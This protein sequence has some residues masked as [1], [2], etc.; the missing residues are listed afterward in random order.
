MLSLTHEESEDLEIKLS[1]LEK[2][3]NEMDDT[4]VKKVDFLGSRE[5]LKREMEKKMN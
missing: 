3:V 4:M 1:Q 2:K 5:K